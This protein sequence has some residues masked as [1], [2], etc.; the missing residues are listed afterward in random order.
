MEDPRTT[1]RTLL[2][3]EDLALIDLWILYWNRGGQCHPLDLD[4]FIHE[5]LPTSDLD[6]NALSY[7]LDDLVVENSG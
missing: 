2:Q 1:A 6:L 5:V 3:Q 7:A 4:A